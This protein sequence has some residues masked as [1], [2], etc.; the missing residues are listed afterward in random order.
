MPEDSKTTGFRVLFCFFTSCSYKN[1]TLTISLTQGNILQIQKR[2]KETHSYYAVITY[3]SETLPLLA[4]KPRH[5]DRVIQNNH[6]LLKNFIVKMKKKNILW[7]KMPSCITALAI[8]LVSCLAIA[9]RTTQQFKKNNNNK[10][11]TKQIDK[12]NANPKMCSKN[13]N[14][15]PNLTLRSF[16]WCFIRYFMLSTNFTS[17]QTKWKI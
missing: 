1:L 8:L 3:A 2:Q 9:D 11:P 10:K 16:S 15:V 4:Y 6:L 7:N 12:K 13:Q 14:K 17:W 5:T